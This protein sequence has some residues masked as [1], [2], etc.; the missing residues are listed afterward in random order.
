LR[1]VADLRLPR[2]AILASHEGSV[3]QAVLDATQ[4][5]SLDARVNVVISNNSNSGALRRARRASVPTAHLSSKTHPRPADLDRAIAT[6]LRDQQTNLVLLA[7]YMKRLG[8][9]TLDA[10]AGHIINTHPSLLPR[11]GGRGLYGLRVH[12]A[13]L[14]N[15]DAETGATVHIVESDYDSGPILAQAR[16]DVRPDDTVQRLE[17]RVKCCE[18]ELLLSTLRTLLTEHIE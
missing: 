2:I 3:L 14:A 5:H 6:L 11:Y 15:G 8:P 1:N 16:V 4:D 7:G 18:R 10:F 17:Q 12:E 9:I 13:V